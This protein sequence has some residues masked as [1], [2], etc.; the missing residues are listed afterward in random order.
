MSG[1]GSILSAGEREALLAIMRGRKVEALKVWRANALVALDDGNSVGLVCRILHLDPDTV[2]G[3]L[4][5]FGGTGLASVDPAAYPERE[6]K[7]TRDQET[8]L[9]EHPCFGPGPDPGFSF[10]LRASG[11]GFS[12]PLSTGGRR[13]GR[14]GRAGRGARPA[15][16]SGPAP[17]VRRRA[18]CGPPT[19][20]GRAEGRS[21]SRPVSA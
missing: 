9:R 15:G 12:T 17:G 1:T 6:G 18:P 7:L 20:A 16:R 10:G 8:S 19:S 21:R 3:W 13:A 2:R 4:R 14:R 11:S 5:G